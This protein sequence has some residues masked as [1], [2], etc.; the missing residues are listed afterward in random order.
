MIVKGTQSTERGAAMVEAALTMLTLLILMFAILEAARM[1]NIQQTLANAAREGARFSVL[2]AA[3]S[4]LPSDTLPTVSDVQARVQ[5]YLNAAGLNGATA[6]VGVLQCCDPTPNS[7]TAATGPP[8]AP[9]CPTGQFHYSRVTVTVPYNVMSISM[10][11]FL[12]VN[13]QGQAT[14]RNETNV[15]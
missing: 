12:Q 6:T 5:G 2:P 1:L 10:F 14:M 4:P 11:G 9:D 7:C 13:L 8:T 3:A 15:K